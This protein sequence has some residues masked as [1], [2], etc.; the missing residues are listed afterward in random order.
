MS[1]GLIRGLGGL[2]PNRQP[3]GCYGAQEAFHSVLSQVLV[4]SLNVRDE[5]HPNP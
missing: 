1:I 3:H 2:K 4:V 5:T